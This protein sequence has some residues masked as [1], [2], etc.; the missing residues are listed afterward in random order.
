[1]Q[2]D[3]CHITISRSYD[4][5]DTPKIHG[6]YTIFYGIFLLKLVNS[7]DLTEFVSDFLE[8]LEIS[9]QIV[10]TPFL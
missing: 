2:I 4:L 10:F 8:M 9:S 1:M 3:S 7:T 5:R 6:K